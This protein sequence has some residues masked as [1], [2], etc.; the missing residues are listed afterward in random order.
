[1][2]FPMVDMIMFNGE[3]ILSTRLEL[4]CDTVD[5]FYITQSNIS[6]SGE[7]RPV[8]IPVPTSHVLP[9]YSKIRWVTYVDDSD[10]KGRTDSDAIWERERRQRE[11]AIKH[12]KR[13][14]PD[15]RYVAIVSDLDELVDPSI[16]SDLVAVQEAHLLEMDMYYYN[17][18]WKCCKWI[19][20][21]VVP[22][23]MLNAG[24]SPNEGR[25]DEK[26]RAQMP[27]IR[28]AGWHAS[29]FMSSESIRH[30]IQ[31]F[32]HQELNTPAMT[33]LDWIQLC[34]ER[35]KDIY[36]RSDT[37][38]TWEDVRTVR[39]FPM[40]LMRFHKHITE[41]QRVDKKLRPFDDPGDAIEFLVPYTAV[42]LSA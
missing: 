23:A 25:R 3:P 35:G 2:I 30:K 6:H 20:G 9:C 16:F 32:A 15:G 12:I 42:D 34:I 17:F 39:D 10:I 18:K 26:T 24:Y 19:K 7:Y 11:Y 21:Q 38:L 28:N 31:Q 36:R 8:S 37:T 33:N 14:Y 22:G 40:P 5:V 4:L 1:M 13:D 27:L 29:Y 41:I